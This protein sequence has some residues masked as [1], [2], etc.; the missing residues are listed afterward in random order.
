M[1]S[2]SAVDGGW[3]IQFIDAQERRRTVRVGRCSKREAQTVQVQVGRLVSASHNNAAPPD[4]AMRWL[5][6]VGDKLHSRLARAGIVQARG[7]CSLMEWHDRYLAQH[8]VSHSI[9]GSTQV[10]WG[11]ERKLMAAYFGESLPL[12]AVTPERLQGFDVWMRKDRGLSEATSRRTQSQLCQIMKAA[13]RAK[14][15]A[16]NP[17]EVADVAR[18]AGPNT[19]RQAFV[20]RDVIERVIE[21]CPDHEWRLLIALARYGG[22]RI[23]SEALAL[24]WQHIDWERGRM[25]VPSPKTERHEG[26]AS[27]LVPIFPELLPHLRDAFERAEEGAR[28]VIGRYR[29]PACNLR[30]A[31][32]RYIARSGQQPWPRLWQNMRSSRETEL[33]ERFPLHVVVAWIGH[34]KQVALTNYLQTL[35]GHFEAALTRNTSQVGGR[36]Q[37][38]AQTDARSDADRACQVLTGSDTPRSDSARN[39][40]SL[41]GLGSAS[42]NLAEPVSLSE[43][44]RLGFEPRS[45]RL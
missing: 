16:V 7:S 34:T 6:G 1:A 31:L 22:L 14:A 32:L 11:R 25:A 10:R 20:P 35:E 41:A 15:I 23:P 9:K 8:A 12:Q 28:W 3:R 38:D 18:N 24:E 13:L 40:R 5:A 42:H 4:D 21:V 27:R 17:F 36:M 37:T 45:Y 2:L 39:P 29:D 43:M 19:K 30:T 26:R 33:A 44:A